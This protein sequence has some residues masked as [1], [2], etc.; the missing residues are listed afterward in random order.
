MNLLIALYVISIGVQ[1]SV[2]GGIVMGA[3]PGTKEA[4]NAVALILSAPLAPIVLPIIA[5]KTLINAWKPN[6]RTETK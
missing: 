3:K 6:E 5:A 4:R 1:V 2:G